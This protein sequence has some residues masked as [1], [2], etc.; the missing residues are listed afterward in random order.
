[1]RDV[2]D[3]YTVVVFYDVLHLVDFTGTVEANVLHLERYRQGRLADVRG[4][5]RR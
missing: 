1:M 2:Y 4:R 5:G 3:G